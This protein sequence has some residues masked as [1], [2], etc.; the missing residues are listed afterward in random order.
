MLRQHQ[1]QHHGGSSNNKEE[2]KEG[3]VHI[4]KENEGGGIS[5]GVGGSKSKVLKRAGL[6]DVT[7]VTKANHHVK[8]LKEI[9]KTPPLTPLPQK[10]IR[11]LSQLIRAIE[12]GDELPEK[13]EIYH[14]DDDDDVSF[15]DE[16]TDDDFKELILHLDRADRTE[17]L[18]FEE[19]NNEDNEEDVELPFKLE[20]L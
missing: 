20:K 3:K 18:P 4:D 17:I 9:L 12:N 2:G 6:S 8:P 5:S 13:E 1:P 19:K 15:V 11:T 7:N 16:V 14:D 10:E